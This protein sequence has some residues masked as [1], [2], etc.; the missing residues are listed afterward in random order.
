MSFHKRTLK[1]CTV[2]WLSDIRAMPQQ[3]QMMFSDLQPM[4]TGLPFGLGMAHNGN[5]VNYFDM[6]RHCEQELQ[7]QLLSTNDLEIFLALW[8]HIL[9][10][11]GIPPQENHI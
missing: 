7:I 11:E 10:Q 3:E 9:Q 1:K 6:A 5:L 8:C 4:V 2:P